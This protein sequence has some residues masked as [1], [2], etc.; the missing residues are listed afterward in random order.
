MMKFSKD[1]LTRK[2]AIDLVRKSRKR[3]DDLMAK[4]VERDARGFTT[5]DKQMAK[6]ITI[7]KEHLKLLE[8]AY[9]RYEDCEFGA[10]AMDCKRPYGNSDVVS[11]IVEILGEEP[12][13]CPHCDELL[14]DFDENR[15]VGLHKDLVDV[16]TILCKFA[17]VGIEVGQTYTYVDSLGWQKGSF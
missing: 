9:W 12:K 15:Y 1:R 10:P 4:E 11:D 2:E 8:N 16:L 5:E 3:V 6:K 14:E 7:L 13:R 17:D